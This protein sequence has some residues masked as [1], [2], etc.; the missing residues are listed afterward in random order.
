[1]YSLTTPY[2]MENNFHFTVHVSLLLVACL[3]F[4]ELGFHRLAQLALFVTLFQS[5]MALACHGAYS[6]DIMAALMFGYFFMILGEKLSYYIDVK[7]FGLTFQERF[8]AYQTE[9][10]NCNYP[11][12]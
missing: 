11:I 4:R 10:A 8:E 6:I 1:M 2:G 3:E 5:V 7:V 12:N 9:C